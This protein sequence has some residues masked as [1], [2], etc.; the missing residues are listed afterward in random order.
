MSLVET[1]LPGLSLSLDAC[2]VALALTAAGRIGD[3]RSALRLCFHFGLFQ[4]LMPVVGWA[5]GTQIE[6]PI[7]SY[8]H[9]IASGLLAFVGVR[10]T[11]SAE[12]GSS[13][14]ELTDPSRR[15]GRSFSLSS[16][17]VPIST[18]RPTGARRRRAC[19]AAHVLLAPRDAWRTGPRDSGVGGAPGPYC[20]A[21]VF[22][23]RSGRHR[24]RLSLGEDLR[25]DRGV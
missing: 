8:D 17:R 7:A 22:A 6:P 25:T 21:A 12:G 10:M 18:H 20:D 1:I 2:A 9:W 19:T 4:F 13:A 24:G 5:A 16:Y 23:P 14:E 11:R 3:R 15:S